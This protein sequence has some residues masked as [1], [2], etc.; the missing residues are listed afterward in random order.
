MWRSWELKR[1]K[2]TPPM[3]PNGSRAFLCVFFDRCAATLLR[4]FA[5]LWSFSVE[6]TFSCAVPRLVDY[7]QYLHV[8][9]QN[10]LDDLGTIKILART[11]PLWT[12]H[13]STP[14]QTSIYLHWYLTS[15]ITPFYTL[16]S[17]YTGVQLVWHCKT[18]TFLSSMLFPRLCSV[19]V[20]YWDSFVIELQP[21]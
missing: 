14:T 21:Y 11:C 12:A 20:L 13:M 5:L 15:T 16:R 1:A 7:A 18:V 2:Q 6:L 9:G 3:L 19:A 4:I 17:K 10:T 8:I